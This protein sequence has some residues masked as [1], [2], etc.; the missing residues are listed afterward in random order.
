MFRCFE[1]LLATGQLPIYNSLYI[2]T[3]FSISITVIEG[4]CNSII[5]IIIIIISSS[6][7][8]SSSGGG[9]SSSSSSSSS[10]QL[11]VHMLLQF[12]LPVF[13]CPFL[14]VYF[15]L[16]IFSFLSVFDHL[17]SGLCR[18]NSSNS[19]SS[20]RRSSSSSSNL[21]TVRDTYQRP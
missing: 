2:C 12:D 21:T 13:S 11:T 1:P 5:I 9:S 17:A 14:Q 18:R 20:I 6:S 3:A 15:Y 7:S 16:V 8:S 4:S 19:S 10:I